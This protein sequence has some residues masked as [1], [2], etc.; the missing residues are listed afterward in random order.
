MNKLLRVEYAGILSHREG[1]F[2]YTNNCGFT[3]V[4]GHNKDSLIAKDQNNG[5]GKSVF[6]G[7]IPNV[8]FE[9]TPL[10]KGKKKGKIHSKGSFIRQH[11]EAGG[12]NWIFEQSGSGY[13]VFRDGEDLQIRKAADANAKIREIL[14]LTE[15]EWYTS[16]Y[17]QSQKALGWQQETEIIRMNYVTTVWRLDQYDIMRK[18]FDKQI[19]EVKNAKAAFDV[20]QSTLLSINDQLNK[21]DWSNKKTRRLEEAESIVAGLHKKVKKLQAQKQEILSLRKHIS[22]YKETTARL[23]KLQGK[24]KF[25]K[26]ELKAQYA[27]IETWE[28]YEEKLDEYK[29]RRKKLEKKLEEFGDI[30]PGKKIKPRMQEL[31]AEIQALE[32]EEGHLRKDLDKHDELKRELDNLDDH[33]DENLRPFL[34]KCSKQKVNPMDTLQEEYNMV[35]AT[36]KLADLL[37]D[38]DDGNCPTCRQK[39]NIKDLEG[40]IATAKKR[41]GQLHSMITALEIR[42]TRDKCKKALEKLN[43]DDEAYW[44]LKATIKKK[45]AELDELADRVEAL[46]QAEAIRDQIEDLK[47]P[48]KPKE[49]PQ[50]T[51]DEIEKYAEML[52]EVKALEARLEEFDEV[53]EDNNLDQRLKEI[54]KKLSKLEEKYS[55][56]FKI[57]VKLGGNAAE[58]KLLQK[59]RDE[60][61]AKIEEIEPLIHKMQM[62]KALSKA[63]SNKGLK[64]RAINNITYQLEQHYNRFANLIFAE[65]FRFQVLTKENGVQVLVDRQNGSPPSDV[66]ELSGAESDSFRLLHFLA[67]I[68]MTPAHRRVNFAILDEPDSHMDHATTALFA[69]QYIPFLRTLVPHVFLITQKGKHAHSNCSYI[70]IEKHKGISRVKQ[71]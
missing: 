4:S 68:I 66:R 42:I 53:P 1:D 5:A 22:F 61:S 38:H 16:V 50:L 39:I 45:K 56:A 43:F 26:A 35:K 69:E 29:A 14:G 12:H 6:F 11:W 3:V 23:A 2:D 18:Y 32:K 36:M 31:R 65:P 37:H 21:L 24:L 10:S 70:T 30:K 52:Q 25:S 34:T 67:G 27:L 59:Q 9:S 64:L 63:Y 60:V 55:E 44:K 62:F 48:K 49:E 57:T 7:M 17:L 47:K 40:S 33:T 54:K 28:D 71:G 8:I 46:A 13:K 51:R 19:D 41:R 58:A 15:D 20:H